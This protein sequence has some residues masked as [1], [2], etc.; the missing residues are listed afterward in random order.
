VTPPAFAFGPVTEADFDELLA[1]RLAVMRDNLE[2]IGRFDLQRSTERFRN[3]F[4]PADTRRIVVAGA[5]AGCVALWA[6]PDG[7]MRVEHFY[8]AVA[9]QRRGLGA[10]VLRALFHE[11]PPSV[12]LFRVGALRDSDAI[13]FYERHGFVKVS[14]GEWDIEYERPQHPSPTR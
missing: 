11:A 3:G 13:R 9:F 14:E 7:A 4:R 5:T 6:E 10:G 2:R 8:L 12:T 1:L